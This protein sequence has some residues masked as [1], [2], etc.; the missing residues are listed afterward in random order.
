MALEV[1]MVD[2]FVEVAV[3]APAASKAVVAAVAAEVERWRPW[4]RARREDIF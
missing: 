4:W 2:G 3:E 1:L